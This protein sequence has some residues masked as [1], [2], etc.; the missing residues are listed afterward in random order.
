MDLM[1]SDEPKF[2]SLANN[3]WPALTCVSSVENDQLAITFSMEELEAV[4]N[5]T[6]TATTLGSDGFQVAFFK[7]CWP[8]VKDLLLNLLNSFVLGT[9]DVS[10]LNFGI[11]SLIPKVSGADSIKQY[12]PIALI[13]VVFKFIAKAF[14]TRLAPVVHRIIAPSQM[15]FFKG[16]VIPDGALSLHEIIHELKSKNLPAILLKLDFEKAY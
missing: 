6:K 5:E 13:N 16:R 8:W 14:A 2:C 15:V 3:F 12:R 9:V 7:K 4:V 11:L 1:G 10:R